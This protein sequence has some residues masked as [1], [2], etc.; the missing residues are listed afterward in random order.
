[1]QCLYVS[2]AENMMGKVPFIPLFL[3]GNS[4][5]TIPHLFSQHKVLGFQFICAD[6][7]AA[8]RRWGSNFYEVNQ[9]LWQF[10]CGKPRLG[11]LTVKQTTVRPMQVMQGSHEKA[12]GRD[13]SQAVR[14]SRRIR[15][16]S[17]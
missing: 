15:P 10:G 13:L 17:K 7:A 16:D 5:T 6:R 4:T 3:A 11:G 14:V 8:D 9:W 1:M 12:W 2:P